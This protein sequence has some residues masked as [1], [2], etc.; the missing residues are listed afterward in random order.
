M[1]SAMRLLRYRFL[2]EYIRG[3][4]Q[5]ISDTQSCESSSDTID[6]QF[7]EDNLRVYSIISISSRNEKPLQIAIDQD[8]T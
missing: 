8:E 6:T 5:L 4:Q 2:L 3:E 1:F 7:L